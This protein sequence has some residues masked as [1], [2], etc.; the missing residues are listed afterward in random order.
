MEMWVL[1]LPRK[2]LP[3]DQHSNEDRKVANPKQF[4]DSTL[5]KREETGQPPEVATPGGLRVSFLF[6]FAEVMGHS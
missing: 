3:E 4:K 2:D 1:G 5:S 6:V